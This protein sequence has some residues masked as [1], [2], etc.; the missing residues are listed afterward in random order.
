M[1]MFSFV[2][3]CPRLSI[4]LLLYMFW[5]AGQDLCDAT[6]SAAPVT[7]Y[8][9]ALSAAGAL[10]SRPLQGKKIGV[11]TEMMQGGVAPGVA[12]AVQN[13]IRHL[14]SLGADISEVSQEQS[15][16]V[17][18]DYRVHNYHVSSMCK[19]EHGH[20]IKATLSWASAL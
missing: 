15:F 10:S 8:A 14:E 3:L 12:S 17:N 19:L 5:D 11:I 9:A 13:S 16:H 18:I 6:S 2:L 4:L 20:I 1:T 7:D